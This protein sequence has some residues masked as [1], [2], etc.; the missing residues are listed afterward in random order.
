[1]NNCSTLGLCDHRGTQYE[2][3][4]IASGYGGYLAQP[5]LRKAYKDDLTRD[6]AKEILETCMKVLFYRDAR[7]IN[8]VLSMKFQLMLIIMF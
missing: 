8:K 1:M 3:N 6:E 5:L 7:T 4:T 2:S